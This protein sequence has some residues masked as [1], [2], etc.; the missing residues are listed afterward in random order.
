MKKLKYLIL[1]CGLFSNLA[2]STYRVGNEQIGTNRGDF[3]Y[4]ERDTISYG[5][6]GRDYMIGGYGDDNSILVGGEGNDFY[7]TA[8][9]SL[10]TISDSGRG[11]ADR[12]FARNI[13]FYC[14]STRVATYDGGKHLI[15][16][17]AVTGAKVVLINWKERLNRIE[18][19]YL[20][21]KRVTY[22]FV[23]RNLTRMYGYLGDLSKAGLRRYGVDM[24]SKRK[25]SN[26]IKYYAW[27]NYIH[28]NKA[29]RFNQGF[30]YV[31]LDNLNK[32]STMSYSNENHNISYQYGQILGSEID[33]EIEVYSKS[34]FDEYSNIY[35]LDN[36]KSNAFSY[37]YKYN[38]HFQL[39]FANHQILSDDNQL[40][41]YEDESLIHKYGVKGTFQVSEQFRIIAGHKIKKD[42]QGLNGNN[43]FF[44]LSNIKS[45]RTSMSQIGFSYD[46]TANLN[47]S[48]TYSQGD[49]ELDIVENFYIKANDDL[50]LKSYGFD[51]SKKQLFTDKDS[52]KFS[53]SVPEYVYGGSASFIVPE[54]FG[55]AAENVDY[56]GEKLKNYSLAYTREVGE[57]ATLNL[58]VTLAEQ[59]SSS[60]R[61]FATITYGFEF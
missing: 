40:M 60:T 22:N 3:M 55:E 29:N 17:N 9:N 14:S 37:N 52:L 36:L 28:Q 11:G 58:A 31:P 21:D 47:I 46:I 13:C 42:R 61:T 41:M 43:S 53:Y 44:N 4:G 19:V 48:S 6:K 56:K 49:G 30:S 50:K 35:T 20:S 18:H 25:T 26:A 59:G 2:F 54:F 8:N 45:S 15:F 12:L 10:I 51:V 27:K 32:I 57:N 33:Q 7:F 34:N 5:L 39:K 23:R 1:F 38:D 16:G 24:P